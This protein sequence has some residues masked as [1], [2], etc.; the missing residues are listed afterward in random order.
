[1]HSTHFVIYNPMANHGRPKQQWPDIKS[2]LDNANIKY[3]LRIT[4]HPHHASS[5]VEYYLL[6]SFK[7]NELPESI[8]VAGGDG[9]IHEVLSGI[10]KA[11]KANSK[12]PNIPI[13][14]IPTGSFNYFADGFHNKKENNIDIGTKIKRNEIVECNIGL[15]DENI[16]NQH[17][18]FL[19]HSGIGLDANILSLKH[20]FN[21]KKSRLVSRFKYSLSIFPIIYYLSV[22]PVNIRTEKKDT[23]SIKNVFMVTLLNDNFNDDNLKLIILKKK[24]F[25]Q[26]CYLLLVILFKKHLKLKPNL[27][28][29]A[30]KIHID[31]PSLEYGH[32]DGENLGSRFYDINYSKTKY[33]F[34]K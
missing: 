10:K 16:K 13:A 28:I 3:R 17:G 21:S 7:N 26:L 2:Q 24:N 33:P 6:S 19:N 1:M 12:I 14:I 27:E 31:I 30:K 5:I 29:N 9:T 32:V 18:F 20:Y 22:F 34:I 11:Q 23:I 25:F 8:I 4:R 15:F